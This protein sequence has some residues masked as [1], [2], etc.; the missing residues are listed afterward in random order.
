MGIYRITGFIL[1]IG[2][3]GLALFGL[4]ARLIPAIDAAP[5]PIVTPLFM[6]AIGVMLVVWHRRE[7]ANAE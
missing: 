5:V 7:A 6:V 2:G 1:I 3:A 4:A